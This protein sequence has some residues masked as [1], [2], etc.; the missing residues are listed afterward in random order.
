MT[1]HWKGGTVGDFLCALPEFTFNL[2]NH[3]GSTFNAQKLLDSI[4]R[5]NSFFK[6]DGS[7]AL[8]REQ[9]ILSVF[10]VTKNVSSADWKAI[11]TTDRDRLRAN[12]DSILH[13]DDNSSS[14]IKVS[15]G[16][17]GSPL[18]VPYSEFFNFL[19]S[20]AIAPWL[21]LAGGIHG[22]ENRRIRAVSIKNGRQRRLVALEP[23][24]GGGLIIKI[25]VDE[26]NVDS[27]LSAI[28]ILDFLDPEIIISKP[29]L[30]ESILWAIRKK[31]RK[32]KFRPALLVSS[33]Q[34]LPPVEASKI[35]AALNCPILD[36]Y[37]TTELGVVGY[38]CGVC[39]CF[40]FDES[41]CLIEE[42]PFSILGTM[43]LND[44]LPIV[45]YK[46]PELKKSSMECITG[47]T[48]YGITRSKP[49]KFIILNNESAIDLGRFQ[50]GRYLNR[51]IIDVQVTA[52]QNRLA[53]EVIL[54]DARPCAPEDVA[55]LR[56]F[57]S[58]QIPS[59]FRLDLCISECSY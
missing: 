12:I 55:L 8:T 30:Y 24:E 33:G 35:Q 49:S 36:V 13:R 31:Y 44:L 56:S 34:S 58:S 23:W 2:A 19:D 25:G 51:N 32:Q 45:K 6:Q 15:S 28:D 54:S 11:P 1:A 16:T 9:V 50:I 21:L 27:L 7:S 46:I 5:S 4:S 43:I 53:I 52:Q 22:Q 48:G 37:A 57:I 42:S 14:Y 59:N 26:R 3:I 40:H 18:K 41:K 38:R 29:S 20:V 47:R 10:G 39:N 17:G